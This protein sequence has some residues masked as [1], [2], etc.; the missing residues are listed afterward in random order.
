M[1]KNSIFSIERV[2]YL[3]IR[4]LRLNSQVLLIAGAAV[5]G[6]LTFILSLR[7]IF[8]HSPLDAV[9]FFGNILPYFFAGGYVFTSTIFSEL[10]TPHRGY[11]YLTLPAS[12]L[13]KLTVAWLI[14]S[15]LYVAAALGIIFIIN[16]LL[17]AM[18]AVFS[19]D[20]V[21][22]FNLLAPSLLKTY[23]VYLV[24]QPVFVLGAIY[25]RR[26]NFF[27]T[28]LALFVVGLVIAIY[29]TLAARLI[30]FHDFRNFQFGDNMPDTVADFFENTFAPV[31]S[32][33]FWCVMGPFF[34]V[35]SY[36]RLKERQV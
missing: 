19:S 1:N 2:G 6:V 13:E 23:A 14:S 4:Q 17:M 11:L 26:V 32:Y 34:L 21:P 5:A 28:M 12:T 30:I 31:V 24:T 36:F 8:G 18:A 20:H 33:L 3:L 16:L 9:T 27:K 25:F 22:V 35:V 15:V 10:R 29:T 7:V